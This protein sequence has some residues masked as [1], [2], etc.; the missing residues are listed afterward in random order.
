MAALSKLNSDEAPQKHDNRIYYHRKFAKYGTK[1][2]NN[3]EIHTR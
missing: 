3:P 1:Q 2:G